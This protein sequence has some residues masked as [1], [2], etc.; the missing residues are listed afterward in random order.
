MHH[1]HIINNAILYLF[2]GYLTNLIFWI[3]YEEGMSY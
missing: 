2:I 1:N 3:D